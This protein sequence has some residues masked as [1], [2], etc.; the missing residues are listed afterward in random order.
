[1]FNLWI[2]VK[3]CGGCDAVTSR[4]NHLSR[5]PLGMNSKTMA[6]K[7]FCF[8]SVLEQQVMTLIKLR[9]RILLSASHSAR[10]LLEEPDC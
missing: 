4:C 9:W 7:S 8:I 5:L 2:S 3:P 10:K 1:M 6:L